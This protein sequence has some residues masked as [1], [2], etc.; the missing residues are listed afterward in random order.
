[1]TDSPERP[2]ATRQSTTAQQPHLGAKLFVT[3]AA[4]T[5]LPAYL[6]SLVVF[7]LPNWWVA[8][9]F[10]HFKLH[11]L[12]AGCLGLVLFGLMRRPWLTAAAAVTVAVNLMPVLHYFDTGDVPGPIG[13]ANAAPSSTLKPESAEGARAP[14]PVGTDEWAHFR[15]AS[16]NIYKHND[17][18][19][20]VADWINQNQPDVVVLL[21]TDERWQREMTDRLPD[22]PHQELVI[23]RN[24]L[25]KLVISKHSVDQM[26]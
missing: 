8:D 21:E 6:L 5:L 9:L 13:P 1:M 7:G 15:I 25:G 16:A 14:L 2:S 24:R 17:R 22:Y 3:A 18:F 11:Y 20:L 23:K 12:A 26:Q 19:D 10:V 4:L